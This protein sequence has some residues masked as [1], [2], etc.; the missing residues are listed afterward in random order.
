MWAI[1][2]NNITKLGRKPTSEKGY[3]D[4]FLEII[5]NISLETEM[6]STTGR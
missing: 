2:K 1:Y 4:K 6:R 3:K 5:R